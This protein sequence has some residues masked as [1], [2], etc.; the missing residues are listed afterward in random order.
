MAGREFD[1]V[2]LSLGLT[3]ATSLTQLRILDQVNVLLQ[4]FTRARYAT[5][6]YFSEKIENLPPTHNLRLLSL[7]DAPKKE[8]WSLPGQDLA[9]L[10]APG[11]TLGGKVYGRS[12]DLTLRKEKKCL[13]ICWVD[14]LTFENWSALWQIYSYQYLPIIFL[15]AQEVGDLPDHE[16]LALS[17]DLFNRFSGPDIFDD[18]DQAT[19]S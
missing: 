7:L 19:L 14:P 13:G 3:P 5:H 18:P 17:G 8:T 12:C 2:F 15:S 9:K 16:W 10:T 11:W 6:I 4:L 1:F